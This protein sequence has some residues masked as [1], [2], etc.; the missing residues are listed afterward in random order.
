VESTDATTG[1]DLFSL[2]G[3]AAYLVERYLPGASLGE[4]RAGA[5]CLA[6]AGEQVADEG[7]AVE[8]LGS[9]FIPGEEAVLDLIL[10]PTTD[11]VSRIT[12][13]AGA[14][15]ARVSE[16]VLIAPRQPDPHR[17]TT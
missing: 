15:P 2:E 3:M 4:V 8:Y 1:A 16:V 13:R 14:R 6:V 5:E 17:P 12:E 11:A 7:I 9:T 10:A